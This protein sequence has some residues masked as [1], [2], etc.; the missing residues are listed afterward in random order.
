M[1]ITMEIVTFRN[2]FYQIFSRLLTPIN[3][4]NCIR[5]K[6]CKYFA[7]KLILIDECEF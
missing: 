6:L 3:V 1:K 4:Y 7:V 5:Y 2:L